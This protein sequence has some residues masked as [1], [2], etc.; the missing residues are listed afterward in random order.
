[1]RVYK[2]YHLD[3]YKHAEYEWFGSNPDIHSRLPQIRIIGMSIDDDT[4]TV[5]AMQAAGAVDY[6]TKNSNSSTLLSAIRNCDTK[7]NI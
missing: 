4:A 7:N 3:G 1:M 2:G 6:L 5:S